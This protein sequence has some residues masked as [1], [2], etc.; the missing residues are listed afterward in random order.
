MSAP[1][2]ALYFVPERTSALYAFGAALLGYDCYLGGEVAYPADL[3]ID[4]ADWTALTQE[5]RR[6]GFHAT[7]KAPFRLRPDRSERE[8]EEAVHAFAA[9]HAPL[10]PIDFEVRL[11][12]GFV[13]LMQARPCDALDRLAADCVTAFDGFRAPLMPEERARRH[14]AA[15]SPAQAENLERWGY[16]YVFGEF[17][18]HMTLTGR[19][20]DARRAAVLELVGARFAA[21]PGTRSAAIDRLALVRQDDVGGRFR[22]VCNPRLNPDGEATL[23]EPDRCA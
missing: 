11:L 9:A 17:R 2:F 15:L 10:P 21:L 23:H 12:D 4:A 18:W 16:P 20:P 19:L 14:A 5:P 22:V 8:L 1:R 6:Y 13:A 3:A 7:I